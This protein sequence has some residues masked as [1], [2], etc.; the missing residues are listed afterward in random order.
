VRAGVFGEAMKVALKQSRVGGP[1]GLL[2][3]WGVESGEGAGE[4]PGGEGVGQGLGEK[5]G[6][7]DGVGAPEESGEEA[8]GE[9][10]G[11][12]DGEFLGVARGLEPEV[13]DAFGF[14][15]IDES[16]AGGVN[17]VGGG[18]GRFGK[19]GKGRPSQ[20]KGVGP[21]G[22]VELFEGGGFRLGDEGG[23]GGE[24]N[25]SLLEELFKKRG[26]LCA[27]GHIYE[28]EDS[29]TFSDWPLC[30]GPSFRRNG[31]ADRAHWSGVG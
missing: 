9:V 2:G 19:E 22:V 28:L 11:G 15:A 5:V 21:V 12:V 1:V 31:T 7:G 24:V 30:R 17:E 6:W 25:T 4:R 13:Q 20:G 26:K 16:P 29:G 14:R 18:E 27:F 3:R 10:D 23:R 8:E